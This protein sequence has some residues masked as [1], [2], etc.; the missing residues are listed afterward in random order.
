[1][2]RPTTKEIAVRFIPLGAVEKSVR[3]ECP[4]C[5]RHQW[6]ALVHQIQKCR[7]GG[8]YHCEH[9]YKVQSIIY[10]RGFPRR[11]PK[12]WTTEGLVVTE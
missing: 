4:Y 5:G 3:V 10:G 9:H 12:W 7:C 11:A 8:R 1:M 2:T 6:T